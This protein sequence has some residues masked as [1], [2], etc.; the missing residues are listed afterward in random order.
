MMPRTPDDSSNGY[1]FALLRIREGVF[2]FEL[3]AYAAASAAILHM[4]YATVDFVNSARAPLWTCALWQ[5]LAH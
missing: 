5:P 2:S 1:T 4:L 3:Y